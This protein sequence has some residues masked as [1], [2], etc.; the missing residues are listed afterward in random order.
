MRKHSSENSHFDELDL[1]DSDSKK[2][3]NLKKR[4]NFPAKAVSNFNEMLELKPN[5]IV[6]ATSQQA[7][8]DYA[9]KTISKDI[10]LI[11]MS[12]GA[13][14]DL[15]LQGWVHVSHMLKHSSKTLSSNLPLWIRSSVARN[16]LP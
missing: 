1:F 7:V 2:T 5:V 16:L 6:E 14:L 11:V 12:A 15:E 10:E 4:R 13:L 9:E 8:M 3:E